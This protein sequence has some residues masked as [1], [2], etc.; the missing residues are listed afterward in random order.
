M[1]LTDVN[2]VGGWSV[3]GICPHCGSP[4]WARPAAEEELPPL[5][6]RSCACADTKCACKEEKE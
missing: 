1:G 3:V 6:T 2:W 5:T 4:V